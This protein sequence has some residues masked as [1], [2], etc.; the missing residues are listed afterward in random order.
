MATYRRPASMLLLFM[1][2]CG[3]LPIGDFDGLMPQEADAADASGRD[4][5]DERSPRAADGSDSTKLDQGGDHAFIRDAREDRDAFILDASR[6]RA[7]APTIDTIDGQS[8][9]DAGSSDVQENDGSYED[10]LVDA[11]PD[12]GEDSAPEPPRDGSSDAAADAAVDGGRGPTI[13]KRGGFVSTPIREATTL[14]VRVRGH[15]AGLAPS[16]AMPS[17]KLTLRGFFR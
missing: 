10:A 9:V 12:R 5:L 16:P 2:G 4:A 15:F 11:A 1:S 7:E 8:V 17:D 6:D 3:L 14:P 13:L